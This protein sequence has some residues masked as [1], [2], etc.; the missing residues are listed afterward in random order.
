MVL[1]SEA[2]PVSGLQFLLR[3]KPARLSMDSLSAIDNVNQNRVYI[4]KTL[5][6][7]GFDGKE[8]VA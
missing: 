5:E 8:V 2:R 3:E 7:T 4:H 1:A 6:K